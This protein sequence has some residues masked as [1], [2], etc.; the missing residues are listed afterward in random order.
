MLREI[1]RT[2]LE[3]EV[4]GVGR[5]VDSLINV[6]ADRK[7]NTLILS[8]P[9]ALLPVAEALIEQL[10]DGTASLGNPTVRVRPLKF[11][12]PNEVSRALT[13]AIANLTSTVTNEPVEVRLIPAAGSN[14][15][16]MVGLEQD[17][18][19]V[20]ALIE[21]LDNRP[22]SDAVD[23][24][25]FRLAHADATTIAPL[26]QNLLTDQMANDPR[27][28]FERIRRSRGEI[29]LE[30]RIRVEAE[31]RTNSLIVS[32]PQQT[33]A[34]AEA[35]INELDAPAED[36]ER[37]VQ[38]FTPERGARAPS[39]STRAAGDAGL[40]PAGDRSSF[41]MI[42]EPTSRSIIVVGRESLA[43]EAVRLLRERDRSIPV[44]PQMD[45][46]IVA[47]EHSDANAVAATVRPHARST[48]IAGLRRC[49]PPPARV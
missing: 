37:I 48:A 42:A 7:T 40:A 46:R 43:N 33:V 10:D 23:A 47:I 39:P 31:A 12:D 49:A 8:A 32:G 3:E 20:E 5:D 2:R 27:V 9:E 41:E 28:V 35:L 21:P 13:Q 36:G 19:A 6:T 30:P 15:L 29:N 22:P 26:V 4:E 17:L 14:A 34:L 16:V 44:P 38:T 1:L 45:L 11:A 24:K 25:T 18:G